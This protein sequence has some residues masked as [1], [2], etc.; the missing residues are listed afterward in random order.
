MYIDLGLKF[1][2][3][4]KFNNEKNNKMTCW[5]IKMSA[6][7]KTLTFGKIKQTLFN[8]VEIFV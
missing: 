1:K 6:T 4:T 5:N 2:V 7:C 3:N 8:H